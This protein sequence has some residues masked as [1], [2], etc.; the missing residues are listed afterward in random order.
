MGLIQECKPIL[1]QRD[2]RD[3]L[4]HVRKEIV[5]LQAEVEDED[6]DVTAEM[7]VDSLIQ[8]YPEKLV[9]QK[10]I[11]PVGKKYIID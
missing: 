11:M 1:A 10:K 7:V 3:L 2:R 8:K 6:V 4:F 5:D 9:F